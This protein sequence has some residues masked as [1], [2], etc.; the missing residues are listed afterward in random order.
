M[1]KKSVS[2]LLLILLLGSLSC[3]TIHYVADGQEVDDKKRTVF[4]LGLASLN[5]NEIKAGPEYEE[6]YEFLDYFFSLITLGIIQTR[7]VVRK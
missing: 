7:T 3:R 2:V 6:K 5:G 1:V 4:L